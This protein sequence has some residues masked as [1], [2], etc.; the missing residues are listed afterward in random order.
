MIVINL[1]S[2]LLAGMFF[3][4]CESGIVSEPFN[5]TITGNYNAFCSEYHMSY[6]A[7][8]AKGLDWD[9]L[10]I[11]YGAG[12]SDTSSEALLY[13]RICGLLDEINDGHADISAL[14][15]GYYRSWNRR[16]S[17]YFADLD[18]QDPS[19]VETSRSHIRSNYMNNDYVS[20]NASGWNFFFGKINRAGREVGYLNIPTFGVGDFPYDLIQSAVDSMNALD[21]AIIDLRYNGGG[22]TESF[23]WCLNTF[24]H[25]EMFYLKSA[26]KNGPAPYAYTDLKEHWIRPHENSLG[27]IPIVVLM[28]DFT[29]S[30]SEHLILGMITQSNV[31]TV[32]TNT[33]G[34]FSSV[35]E[36]M[37]PNGWKFRL[38]SQVIFTPGG[39]FYTND[40]GMYI[41]GLGITPDH[42]VDDQYYPALSGHDMS[43]DKAL[44]LFEE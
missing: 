18:T 10:I 41:E 17:S 23:V 14:D 24:V 6:G 5:N 26:F 13:Q 19:Y 21:G 25:E 7:F 32:G 4:A 39:E 1:L 33:C 12:L 30:S 8:G 35:R 29:A 11:T 2:V 42:V 40:S 31:T 37:L 44:S 16:D 27:E 34:A 38:G 3:F 36:C 43:L 15:H 22:T 20:V 28:N 9:S